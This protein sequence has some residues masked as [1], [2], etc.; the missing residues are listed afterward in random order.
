MVRKHSDA[1]RPGSA[2]PETME[3]SEEVAHSA[4]P[5][6]DGAPTVEE[7]LDNAPPS[8]GAPSA[9]QRE[10]EEMRDRY[11]RLAAEYDN[12][13]KRTSR[14]SAAA[15]ARA[16]GELAK[17]LL[18]GLDDLARVADLDPAATDAASVVQG[19]ELVERKLHKSLAQAGLEIVNPQDQA[20]N[21]E[22]HEAVATEPAERAEDDDLVSRV[23]QQGYLFAG[24][25][26][27]PARV[28]VKKWHG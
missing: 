19:V 24:Q 20:F 13:R 16:Q 17:A 10:L 18:D 23:Y 15:G 12:Y 14:E 1:S 11:L 22:M 2:Q 7:V 21:P 5:Q 27:R 4:E 8:A 25:L 9:A 26:L 3:R 28:V 6:G